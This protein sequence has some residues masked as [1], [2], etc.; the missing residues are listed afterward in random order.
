MR[1]FDLTLSKVVFVAAW[2][3]ML[4][5]ERRWKVMAAPK[6]IVLPGYRLIFRAWKLDRAGNRMYAKD[7]GFRAWPL[8]IRV[9][10]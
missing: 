7:Y 10:K 4:P 1:V 8:F 2:R 9:N 3:W 6:L 5:S